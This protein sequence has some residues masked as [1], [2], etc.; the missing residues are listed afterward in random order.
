M[1]QCRHKYLRKD[2]CLCM[3]WLSAIINMAL[4]EFEKVK[5]I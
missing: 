5:D 2:C 4:G 1:T 3:A